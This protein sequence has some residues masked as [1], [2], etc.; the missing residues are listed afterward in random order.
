MKKKNTVI[1]H[2]FDRW[3]CHYDTDLRRY[4]YSAPAILFETISAYLDK[5]DKLRLLDV[6][7]GTGLSA[8]PFQEQ[9][10]FHITGVDCSQKML[11]ICREKPIADELHLCNVAQENLPFADNSFDLAISAGVIEYVSD[12]SGLFSEVSR[13]LRPDGLFAISWETPETKRLYKPGLLKGILEDSKH[14][15]VIQSAIWRNFFPRTYK[16][17]LYSV[18]MIEELCGANG[19]TPLETKSFLAYSPKADKNITHCL[20]I[21]RFS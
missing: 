11:D 10:G 3:S 6:G 21:G 17:Y 4:D 5:K 18:E 9:G 1:Q 20:L 15:V 7:I 19:I 2:Y 8:F 14:R 12:I 16:R 13:V